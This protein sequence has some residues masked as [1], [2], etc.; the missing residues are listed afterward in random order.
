MSEVITEEVIEKVKRVRSFNY[1]NVGTCNIFTS[2]GRCSCGQV[3][4]LKSDEAKT[5]KGLEKC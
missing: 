1:K 2:K 3:V 5:H 4:N